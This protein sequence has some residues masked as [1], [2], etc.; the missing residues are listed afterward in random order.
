MDGASS[1]TD[2]SP[3]L[4]TSRSTWLVGIDGSESARHAALWA[5]AHAPGRADEIQLSIAWSMPLSSAMNPFDP[6]VLSA[7]S[8]AMRSGASAT[9]DDL[10]ARLAPST[11]VP[12]TVSV[13]QGGAASILLEGARHSSLLV[14]GSR[15]R[16]GFSRLL[17]GSTSGHCA[18]HASV[19]VAIV[20]KTA[21]LDR[22]ANVLVA[23]DGSETAAAAL[24]WAV[25]FATPGSTIECVMV[26]DTTPVSVGTDELIFPDTTEHARTRFEAQAQAVLDSVDHADLTVHTTLLEGR[27]RPVLLER[28]ARSD[29]LVMGARGHGA[30]G[31]AILG[32][33]SNW[34]LHHGKGPMIIVPRRGPV[35]KESESKP[36]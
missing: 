5:C 31:A 16:G 9:V 22:T 29:L 32:S 19:P 2:G 34:L 21:S 14:V 28:A 27:P 18:A 20:P 17:L 15:G 26:W 4:T 3:R 12:V 35:D 13:G 36:D 33:V 30:V 6:L 10:A 11:S 23:F 8:D 1:T 24:R 7:S 25:D